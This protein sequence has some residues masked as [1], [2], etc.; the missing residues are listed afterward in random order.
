MIF[1]KCVR[2]CVRAGGRAGVRA[3]MRACVRVC[4]CSTLS[5]LSG[6]FSFSSVFLCDG[7]QKSVFWLGRCVFVLF[8][9]FY[10]LKMY[11]WFFWMI[12]SRYFNL[13][14]SIRK[15]INIPISSKNKASSYHG[16]FVINK[17]VFFFKLITLK[18]NGQFLWEKSRQCRL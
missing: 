18:L 1:E 12:G 4:V 8:R 2:A 13:M 5:I 11:F 17:N 3:C 7:G 10:F 9:I 16:S 6:E 14:G 15:R